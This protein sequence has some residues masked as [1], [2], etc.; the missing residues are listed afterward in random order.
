MHSHAHSI[1]AYLESPYY[2][3]NSGWNM[4]TKLLEMS[5]IGIGNTTRVFYSFSRSDDGKLQGESNDSKWK[6]I[7]FRT[8]KA[9]CGNLSHSAVSFL[10]I[11]KQIFCQTPLHNYRTDTFWYGTR[12]VNERDTKK[13][14]VCYRLQE[15]AWFCKDAGPTEDSC[16]ASKEMW[17]Q[18]RVD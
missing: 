16:R 5:V 1:T 9:Y 10:A 18:W 13:P 4:G 14:K 2:I 15:W 3:G 6:V 17:R 8:M 12:Q 7:E 11:P